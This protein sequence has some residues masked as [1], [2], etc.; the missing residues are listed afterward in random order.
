MKN[1]IEFMFSES[2]LKGNFYEDDYTYIKTIKNPNE[3]ILLFIVHGI[4][5]S[6]SKLTSS[7]NKI[8]EC[9]E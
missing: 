7:L 3:E 5:Q 6:K 8:N 1:N 4:G 2:T 9:L